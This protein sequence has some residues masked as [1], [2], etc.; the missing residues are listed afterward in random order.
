MC[1]Y[2][3][4]ETSISEKWR[5][6]KII[7]VINHKSQGSVVTRLRCG[8]LFSDHI[9]TNS[10]LSLTVKQF[11]KSVNIWQSYRQESWSSLTRSMRLGTVM[12]N[13]EEF[14]IDF[15]YDTTVVTCKPLILTLTRHRASASMYSLTFCV[16]IMSPERHH[17]KPAVQ[18]AAV[19]LRTPPSPAGH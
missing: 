5:L 1:C 10:L 7:I 15:S 6:S 16:R 2:T 12:L 17:W 8:G 9:A 14:A 18:A 11:L 3:T 4:C 19:M 13:D